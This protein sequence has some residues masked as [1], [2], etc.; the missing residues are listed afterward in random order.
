MGISSFGNFGG[1]GTQDPNAASVPTN[2]VSNPGTSSSSPDIK[3]Y[4]STLQRSEIEALIQMLA[5]AGFPM[6]M[7]P[8]FDF[9]S[10]LG[11]GVGTIG[12]VGATSAA[13]HLEK[14]KSDIIDYMWKTF[15][16][17][18]R[19]LA[20][21][22]EEEFI[23]HWEDRILQGKG[24]QSASEYYAYILTLSAAKRAEEL[25]E[26]GINMSA[27]EAQFNSAFSQWIVVPAEQT[28]DTSPNEISINPITGKA[29]IGFENEYPNS[30]FIAATV[31]G[32]TEVVRDAIGQVG[33]ALGFQLSTNPVADALFAAGPSSGLPT[34][35]QAA[36]ALVAA[37]LNGGAMNKATN[38]TI[39]A[40]AEGGQPLRNLDF[41]MNY[42]KNIIKI[43]T[44][45]IEG[46]Q[47]TTPEGVLRNNMIR[48]MLSVMALNMVYRAVYDGMN[49]IE[50]ADIL[51]GNTGDLDEAIKP[52]I[53]QLAGIINLLMPSDPK[54]RANVLGRL[55]NYI[56]GK[57][58]IDS[59]L[60]T[61]RLFK[62]LITPVHRG[63]RP[64]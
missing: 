20:V 23:K 31:V 8:N 30:S 1:F 10:S 57:Q 28:R 40:A 27:L 52:M 3:Y 53:E 32:S 26:R 54:E 34:D 36:A 17:T 7:P 46:T 4:D 38:D 13:M 39:K 48:L 2:T 59:M 9:S 21:K 44:H 24:P 25:H 41:A 16:N 19:E 64:G 18:I 50:F 55:M 14:I 15:Q 11:K 63:D 62:G 29:V 6:L 43:V 49:G 22:A 56:D 47:A 58:S 61:T 60:E 42:A 5:G 12:A 45:D 33:A 51:N 37:L 35:I